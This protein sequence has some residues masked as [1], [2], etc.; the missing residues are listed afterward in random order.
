MLTC[1][2]RTYV[3]LFKIGNLHLIIQKNLT[4]KKYNAQI[5]KEY[6]YVCILNIK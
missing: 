6:Y 4:F 1:I 2:I 3:K 5:Q